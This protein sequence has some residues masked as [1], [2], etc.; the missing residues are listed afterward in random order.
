MD[1]TLPFGLRSAPKIFLAVADGITWAMIRRGVTNP[2]HYLDD[3]LF[4]S[5]PVV[6]EAQGNLAL[7]L[8]V[9]KELGA[10]V[11]PDKVAGPAVCIIFLGIE[12]DSARQELRL[13]AD[14]LARLQQL[15]GIWQSRRSC[16]KTDL[17]S[18]IGHLQHAATVVRPGRTFVRR[19]IDLAACFRWI[20]H[21]IRLNPPFRSDLQWWAEFLPRWNGVGFFQPPEHSKTLVS[22]ASGSWGCGAFCLPH[23]LQLEWPSSWLAHHIAAKELVPILLAVAVWGHEWVGQRV[24]CRCDNAAVVAVINS[25]TAKDPLLMHLL[26]CLFF[27]AAHYKFTLSARHLPGKEHTGADAISRNNSP[28]F[29]SL[30]SQADRA[31][32]PPP[33]AL[34]QIAILSRPNWTAK[35]WK[36]LFATTLNRV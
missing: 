17:L 3:F 25:G 29:L 8:S 11:A 20:D 21:P 22:D 36:R 16:V 12:I 23:W 7:A 5:R 13:P 28:L 34:L 27:Y 14:K 15:I 24:L 9:C 1:A 18:L 10:P 26:R 35:N 2:L 31:A 33:P 32:A 19:M 6:Q 30:F 4:V